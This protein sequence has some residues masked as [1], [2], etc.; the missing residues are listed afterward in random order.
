MT[1]RELT[2]EEAERLRKQGKRV[3]ELHI[4]D[5]VYI[6]G[7]EPQEEQQEEEKQSEV[8]HNE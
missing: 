3:M 8:K 1:V 5:K 2:P 4:S 7:Q 6:K